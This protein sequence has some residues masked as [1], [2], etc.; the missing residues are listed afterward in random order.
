MKERR[1][2]HGE[3][4][5]LDAD[6]ER[7]VTKTIADIVRNDGIPV[8]AYVICGDHV[9]MVIEAEDALLPKIVGKMKAQSSRAYLNYCGL[10]YLGGHGHL[11]AQKF[12]RRLIQSEEQFANTV[13]YI[14]N[15]RNKHGLPE[16]NGLSDVITRMFAR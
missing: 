1:L 9:H 4:I 13:A 5:F 8:H 3:G 12:N 16:N 2:K 10:P 15:N 11:W 6:A 7:V 14:R